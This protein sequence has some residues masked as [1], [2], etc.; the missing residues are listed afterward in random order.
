VD[1]EGY[2]HPGERVE[3]EMIVERGSGWWTLG[4]EGWVNVVEV[5]VVVVVLLLLLLLLF[6]RGYTV[7]WA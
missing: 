2:V 1:G 6:V 7:Q 5:D 4:L 3:V